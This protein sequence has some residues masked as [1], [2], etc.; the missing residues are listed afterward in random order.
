MQPS[1]NMNKGTAYEPCIACYIRCSTFTS[2]RIAVPYQEH[3]ITLINN[4][5]TSRKIRIIG[6]ILKWQAMN[7]LTVIEQAVILIKSFRGREYFWIF[8]ARYHHLYRN[9]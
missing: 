7:I 9:T 3:Q 1:V 6:T 5:V 4:P 8:G 2:R